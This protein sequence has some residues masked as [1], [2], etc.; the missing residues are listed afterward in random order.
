M[1]VLFHSWDRLMAAAEPG[2]EGRS[3]W[4]EACEACMDCMGDCM[5][6]CEEE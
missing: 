1:E 6:E 4:G 3:W 2:V 5:E